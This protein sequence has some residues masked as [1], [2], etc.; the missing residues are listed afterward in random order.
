[1]NTDKKTT[2]VG[3]AA[4][5]YDETGKLEAAVFYPKIKIAFDDI[6]DQIGN[7]T[8][9]TI[10]E[11]KQSAELLLATYFTRIN[12]IELRDIETQ[13]LKL[14]VKGQTQYPSGSIKA[15]EIDFICEL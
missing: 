10:A 2:I 4:L 6:K 13:P 9:K 15:V 3:S 8:N 11:I 1:M 7:C 14:E 5:E 12:E